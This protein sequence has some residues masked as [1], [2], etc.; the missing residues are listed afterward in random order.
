M[1]SVRKNFKCTV[2]IALFVALATIMAPVMAYAA[3]DYAQGEAL[4]V[5]RNDI[6]V[7]SAAS[8]SSAVNK[9]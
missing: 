2:F 6:G 9:A 5:L 7:L 1:E 4:V 8:I 3:G